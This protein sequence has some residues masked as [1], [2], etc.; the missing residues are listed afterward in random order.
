VGKP[1]FRENAAAPGM[2]AAL[3]AARKTRGLLMRD[4]APKLGRQAAHVSAFEQGW[5]RTDS[6][7]LDRWAAELGYRWALIPIEQQ[8]DDHAET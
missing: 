4:L 2:G 7:F 5:G 8:E 1:Q 6:R 3:R